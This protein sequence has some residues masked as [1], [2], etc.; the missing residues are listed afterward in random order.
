MSMTKELSVASEEKGQVFQLQEELLQKVE[1]QLQQKDADIL[2][3]K[4]ENKDLC[5][6]L[7]N[8]S[9]QLI[10]KESV[11]SQTESTWQSKCLALE[12]HY[13][14]ELTESE[15]RMEVRVA[16]LAELMS[17]LHRSKTDKTE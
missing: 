12:V 11:F 9:Q 2:A 3:L 14:K 4:K 8:V 16:K 13:E 17:Q 5:E 15:H 1:Q 6:R 7:T 10:I